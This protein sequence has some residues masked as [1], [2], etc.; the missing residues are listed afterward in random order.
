MHTAS[1]FA[2]SRDLVFAAQDAGGFLVFC[3]HPA[4]WCLLRMAHGAWRLVLL[5]FAP[6]S[7]FCLRASSVAPVRGGT[8]FSLPPQ[9]KV[10]KRKR[11]TPPTFLPA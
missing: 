9:R 1:T 8:Y 2:G 3:W 10:G 5:A 6:A 11:L 7:A 4:L